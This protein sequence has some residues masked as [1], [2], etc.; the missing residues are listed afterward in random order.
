MYID[1][2]LLATPNFLS[3]N[4]TRLTRPYRIDSNIE[5]M[6]PVYTAWK[7]IQLDWTCLM[8]I[9]EFVFLTSFKSTWNRIFVFVTDTEMK[10]LGLEMSD[11][12]DT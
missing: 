2:H 7:K 5:L 9:G 4:G 10:I 8:V 6:S 1:Q 11:S 3:L 12:F